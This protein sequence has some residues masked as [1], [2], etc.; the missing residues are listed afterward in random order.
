[1]LY[2]SSVLKAVLKNHNHVFDTKE[3]LG[4]FNNRI[5]EHNENCLHRGRGLPYASIYPDFIQGE[6][7]VIMT[8]PGLDGCHFTDT[9]C[10]FSDSLH[11]DYD[12]ADYDYTA[13]DYDEDID[14]IYGEEV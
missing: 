10:T 1:M 13:V 9:F 6:S 12:D 7:L 3:I 14:V 2:V 8:V 11:K 4:D 5:S